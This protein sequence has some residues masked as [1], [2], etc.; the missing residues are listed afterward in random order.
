MAKM[1]LVF[2]CNTAWPSKYTA[3]YE[4]KWPLNGSLNYNIIELK[5][6]CQWSGKWDEI[7]YVQAFMSLYNKDLA[8][9]GYYLMMW[10]R[11]VVSKP[12]SDSKT[13]EVKENRK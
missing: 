3:D 4:G 5:L 12:L 8:R 13:Q 10:R 9:K 6:C 7:P 11:E 2:Y 1:K